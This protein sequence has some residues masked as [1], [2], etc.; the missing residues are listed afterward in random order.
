VLSS[1]IQTGSTNRTRGIGLSIRQPWVELILSGR[2]TIEVRSWR[3]GHRGELWLHAGKA[4]DTKACELN[5]MTAAVLPRGALV[6]VGIIEDCFEFSPSSWTQHRALHMNYI[7][8]RPGLFGWVFA[9][10]RRI[11]PIPFVGKLGLM[12]L[13]LDSGAG[14]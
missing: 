3:T 14:A 9:A 8:F 2:K 10:V 6:G 12:K 13:D 1:T 5:G 4:I 7:D 11:R